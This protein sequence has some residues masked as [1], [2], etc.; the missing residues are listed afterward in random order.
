M[1]KSAYFDEGLTSTADFL[2]TNVENFAEGCREEFCKNKFV[3]QHIRCI[4]KCIDQNN[5]NIYYAYF[6]DGKTKAQS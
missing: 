1:L 3:L 5:S 4:V 6:T 2:A